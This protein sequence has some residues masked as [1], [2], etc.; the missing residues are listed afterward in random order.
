MPPERPEAL[1]GRLPATEAW[2]EPTQSD[3]E[4]FMASLMAG[5]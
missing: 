4:R 3:M 5:T 1:L 2:V